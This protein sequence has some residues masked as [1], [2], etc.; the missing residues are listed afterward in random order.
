MADLYSIN[1]KNIVRISKNV[2]VCPICQ[3][4]PNAMLYKPVENRTKR[5]PN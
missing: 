5:Y 2:K 3:D 4:K 1:Q